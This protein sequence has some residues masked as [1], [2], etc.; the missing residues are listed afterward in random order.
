MEYML[1]T[2]WRTWRNKTESGRKHR[3]MLHVQVEKQATERNLSAGEPDPDILRRDPETVEEEHDSLDE[4]S[5]SLV[6]NK[7]MCIVCE[8]YKDKMLTQNS[9]S[10]Y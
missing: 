4:L 1:S 7:E 9:A 10:S 5:L 3:W 8:S 6:L 2:A